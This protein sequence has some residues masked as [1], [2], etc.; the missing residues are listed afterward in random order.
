MIEA[1]NIE[2]GK[3]ENCKIDTILA[4]KIWRLVTSKINDGNIVIAFSSLMSYDTKKVDIV[5][6]KH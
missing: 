1:I 2:Y 4:S 5:A 3:I 6:I